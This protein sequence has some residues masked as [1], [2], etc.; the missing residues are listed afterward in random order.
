MDYNNGNLFILDEKRGDVVCL[1]E[2][3]KSMQYVSRHGEAPYETVM[4]LTF[5]VR[6]DTTYIVDFGTRSMKKYYKGEF[7]DDF[8]LSNANGNRFSVNESFIFLSATTDTTS[9]LRIP[10]KNSL[11][12]EAIGLVTK[13]ATAK[14][15]IMLNQKHILYNK[16]T[17]FA[18][19]GN[20]PYIQSYNTDG[21]LINTFDISSIPVIKNSIEY[22]NS[23]PYQENS[24]YIYIMDAYLANDY[25][26]LL[27]SSRPTSQEYK[28]NTVLKLSINSG[29][30]LQSI[31]TL[32]HD[33]YST[34]CISDSHIFAAQTGRNCSIEKIIM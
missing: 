6:N 24:Y 7:I 22:A 3:F 27:C 11:Q 28:V 15:T 13:E 12:Q 10:L 1:D 20:Y 23:L 8:P 26:Y 17:I 32:P 21:N 34:F 14:R 5:S 18:V 30:T 19:S 4:P 29:M 9:Y 2:N 25:I 16:G 31:Y 33:Y